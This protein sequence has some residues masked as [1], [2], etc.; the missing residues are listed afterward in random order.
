MHWLQCYFFGEGR[1]RILPQCETALTVLRVHC[2]FPKKEEKLNRSIKDN[3]NGK[4]GTVV[5]SKEKARTENT[6]VKNTINSTRGTV[7][8]SQERGNLNNPVKNRV[9]YTG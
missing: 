7:L 8:F 1:N 9:K 2:Y 5:F 3:I 4:Q 6:S